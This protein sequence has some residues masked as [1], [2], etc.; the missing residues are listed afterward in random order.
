MDAEGESARTARFGDWAPLKALCMSG[1]TAATRPFYAGEAVHRRVG[2]VRTAI[3][4]IRSNWAEYPRF[5]DDLRAL[6]QPRVDADAD[7]ILRRR[8]DALFSGRRNWIDRSGDAALD[9]TVIQLYTSAAGYRHMF[10]VINA[11]FRADALVD[12]SAELRAA[13]FLVELLNIDLFNH[14][15]SDAS[16]SGYRGRVYRGMCVSPD[17][18]GQFS[19]IAGGPVTERYVS[20]PL[21]MVSTSTS[22]ERALVFTEAE[23][24]RSADGHPLLWDIEV[25][26]LSDA[27]LE[28]YRAAFPTSVVSTICAVPIAPL[29]DFPDEEE[30]LLRG[31]FFQLLRVRPDAATI[32]GRTLHVAEALMLTANRDHPS[33]MELTDRDATIARDLFRTIVTMDRSQL[34]ARRAQDN[35]SGADAAAFRRLAQAQ[36]PLLDRCLGEVGR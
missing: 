28:L 26:G 5:L 27:R 14:C 35:G 3:E 9:R 20:I 32:A 33:T 23:V 22:R 30:V 34:C 17:E 15:A 16:A 29:S 24:R 31:P 13:V 36:Q 4:E 7:P 11:A 6:L 1:G 2:L 12:D 25:A 8:T 19:A 10:S 21:A 18:L